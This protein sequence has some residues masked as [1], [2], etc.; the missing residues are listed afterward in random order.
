[1][2][3][4][5]LDAQLQGWRLNTSVLRWVLV[6]DDKQTHL[7]HNV[8]FRNLYLAV[9]QTLQQSQHPLFDFEAQEHTAQVDSGRRQELERR[10]RYT[11]K[12]RADGADGSAGDA[13]LR[14]L[15]LMFCSPTMELGVDISALNAVYLR[16]VPPTPANYAQRSGRAGRSGMQA[17]VITY[18]AALSPHDQW[19]FRRASDMVHG[20][21]KPPTL[22]LANKDL[23]ESHLHA[24]WLAATRVRLDSSIA[25]MLDL[26]KEDQPL[27]PEII[28]A[29]G[30][31]QTQ[32]RALASAQAFMQ[33][34][35]SELQNSPWFRNDHVNR[36]IAAAPADLSQ[37]MNRWRT[38]VKA[39]R[40]QMDMAHSVAQSYTT[41]TAEK[42][43]AKRRYGDAANQHALLLKTG[44]GQNNDFYT[45]RYLASQ[46]FLPGYNFPRLPLM[47][48]M[49]AQGGARGKSEGW[50]ICIQ[51][52]CASLP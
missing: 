1:M 3:K 12:D 2:Q 25:P 21:V 13:P 24:I 5:N 7:H 16:N 50:A 33:Q 27:K 15:P 47:A 26:E 43:N 36:I 29:I 38:M 39:T 10:F 48:W 30:S 35:Q 19:F 6:P 51:S 9:A 37:A 11:D 52:Q 8:F 42:V 46:G 44:N 17:L 22:D 4:F 32:Q 14:R 41:S 28:E 34:L 20:I 45:Y 23:V 18:C 31:A 49:P 40:Q